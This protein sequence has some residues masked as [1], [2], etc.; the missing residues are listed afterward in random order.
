M[1]MND[2]T[3]LFGCTVATRPRGRQGDPGR[4]EGNSISAG[5]AWLHASC[6]KQPPGTTPRNTNMETTSTDAKKY[7][8]KKEIP[9]L[10]E[11]ILTGL[12]YNRPEDHISYI[13]NC[14]QQAK[15]SDI[16]N[17]RWDSFVRDKAL[18]PIPPFDGTRSTTFPTEP[19]MQEMNRNQ[20]L[21]PIATAPPPQRPANIILV[22]G[23]PGSGK[24]TQCKQIE[25][26][27]GYPHLSMGEILRTKIMA[28]GQPQEKW[29]I[30]TDTIQKGEL[31]PTADTEELEDLLLKV[32]IEYSME[33]LKEKLYECRDKPG[34]VIEGFPRTVDHMH[35]FHSIYGPASLVIY[36]DCDESRLET[37]LLKR[38]EERKRLD[39]NVGAVMR[40]LNFFKENNPPILIYYGAIGVL[41]KVEGDRDSDAVFYDVSVT[42][43]RELFR[44]RTGEGNRE[45]GSPMKVTS[46]L[47]P[48]RRSPTPPQ[49]P[50]PATTPPVVKQQEPL[51]AI[52]A[53][54]ADKLKGK[55]VI[56]VV[57]GPGC[58][59]G[60]QCERIVA[61]YG[62]THLSSG[63]L[64]RDEVKSGSERGK[65]LTEIMEQGKLVPMATVLELLRDA[66]IAKADTSNGFLIDGYPREVIQGTEFES[67]IQECD[68]VLYFECSAETMTERLLGRAK[69][70]GRVDDNEETIKKRLDTFYSA[71][72]PVVSHYEEKGKLRKINA[73]REVEA[74]FADVCAALDGKEGGKEDDG[75]KE[76][77]LQGKKVIFVVGG[78]GCG[79]GT[80]CER[81]VAKYGYTHLSSGDLL[82][83]EVKSGSERGKKLTEI[84]EKGELVPMSVVLDLLKEAMLA[85][86]GES[87]GFLID[88]YPREVQQ[89]A[90]FEEKIASCDCV[91]YFECSDE[92]MTERLLGRAKTSGRVDDNEETIKK[93]LTTFHNATEPVVQY[94]EDK[95][96][97]AKI[98]AER[99]PDEVFTDVCKV[100]GG[101]D[102][103][104]FKGSKVILVCG[105]PGSGKG[106]Q[107][108]RVAVKYGLTHLAMHDLIQAEVQSGSERGNLLA[109]AIKKG[110]LQAVYATTVHELLSEAMAKF[111]GK[112]QGFVIDGYLGSAEEVSDFE[113]KV[114]ELACA[115]CFECSDDVMVQR[116]LKRGEGSGSPEDGEEAI[117]RR[118]EKFHSMEEPV[119][120]SLEGRGKA[121]KIAAGSGED[122]VF[123]EVCTVLQGEGIEPV[124]SLQGAAD[125]D[126]AQDGAAED[127]KT[128]VFT[129]ING[130]PG[131]GK[132]AIA[133]T[134]A[135]ETGRGCIS[136]G[137]VLRA[138]MESE[139]EVA[140]AI[141]A[142]T[143][144]TW[145]TVINLVKKQIQSREDCSAGCVVGGLPRTEE[146]YD[147][148]IREI[149]PVDAV[150]FLTAPEEVLQQNLT[151]KPEE[152]RRPDDAED[153]LKV[154]LQTYGEESAKVLGYLKEHGQA[155]E[156]S[157]EAAM[158]TVLQNVRDVYNKQTGKTQDS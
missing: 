32:D 146:Q 125:T 129:F 63:D 76:D 36:L 98:S 87:Q 118:V 105:G 64:L 151:G 120:Q 86:A 42:I 153:V 81:I 130:G 12:M 89:G 80:Q 101:E 16:Q 38:A 144:V 85:K 41:R 51:P 47:P 46:P 126:A 150:V 112:T 6:R 4:T 121:R 91:L 131:T 31:A 24:G 49:E 25:A 75:G 149:G 15:G 62:Y 104:K 9:Q 142:G 71:T 1:Q 136:V 114:A 37:R 73:E 34:V 82:R 128:P 107:C 23:G 14:L 93:R 53:D 122:E 18:P 113:N 5:A 79:K 102:G 83:D 74:I 39:D 65:K 103:P 52:S 48:I 111:D 124:S 157:W 147:G 19:N 33:L 137:E 66:M 3:D 50:K 54:M 59:K 58:G 44:P 28:D 148:F 72:E 2:R 145:K 10:F 67:N 92:T 84:M 30:I 109:E 110:E 152:M 77:S 45:P 100:L 155:T 106:T 97:L 27:Y 13:E 55:K 139:P 57:G 119:L 123:A 127:K 140:E 43:D 70:S 135:F 17:L 22:L 40:R 94:Y 35:M 158:E 60:T 7:L 78:P 134:L 143:S 20:V 154:R 96:K 108:Q 69:T 132:K 156:V 56:F 88:G 29:G 115:L 21:P 138:E 117:K 11:S 95:K 68:C 133:E 90:E 26:R 61:K 99:P 141:N 116:S 8:S